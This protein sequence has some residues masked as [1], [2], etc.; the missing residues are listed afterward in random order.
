MKAIATAAGLLALCIVLAGALPHTSL[1]EFEELR[2]YASWQEVTDGPHKVLPEI[3]TRCMVQIH[4][5]AFDDR[6]NTVNQYIRVFA[7]S[8]A[9]SMMRSTRVDRF[10][11][12]TT[13]AKVKLVEGSPEPVGVAFMVKRKP[14]FNPEGRDWEYFLFEGKAMRLSARGVISECRFCHGARDLT[15]GLFRSYLSDGSVGGK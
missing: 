11:T 14:G 2:G 6:T 12:G 15:D 8:P 4:P 10:P 9:S 3:S 5:G 1:T 13:V 7:T